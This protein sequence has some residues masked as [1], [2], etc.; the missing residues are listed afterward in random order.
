MSKIKKSELLD[1]VREQ[2]RAI[3]NL[4][5]R[6]TAL[7]KPQNIAR[8]EAELKGSDLCRAMIAR[9]DTEIL[10]FVSDV[11]DEQALIATRLD[12]IC[13]HKPSLFFN[14]NNAWRRFAVPVDL[15]RKPIVAKDVGL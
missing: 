2:G 14:Q 5:Q 8:G 1:I 4:L 12:L 13:K 15:S 7:E 9:G 11:S 10:C 6:V 3:T